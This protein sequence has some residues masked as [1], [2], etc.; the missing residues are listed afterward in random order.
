MFGGGLDPK[1]VFDRGG[2]HESIQGV[3]LKAK[4]IL[5]LNQVDDLVPVPRYEAS[6]QV[7][8]THDIMVLNLTTG[9]ALPIHNLLL[10]LELRAIL[11]PLVK[12]D[13]TTLRTDRR[14]RIP[15]LLEI[16]IIEMGLR[17]LSEHTLD[18]R[19]RI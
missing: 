8:K 13:D 11:P 14:F 15:D 1:T 10:R 16:G 4:F 2:R 12:I 19:N 7:N 9:R 6:A 5:V 18:G 3:T 17:A